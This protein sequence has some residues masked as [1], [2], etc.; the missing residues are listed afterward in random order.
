MMTAIYLQIEGMRVCVFVRA[1][2]PKRLFEGLT[3][4]PHH[5]VTA[6]GLWVI[7]S[8]CPETM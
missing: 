4:S 8:V 1:S 2:V 7:G 5:P 6:R 3:Q